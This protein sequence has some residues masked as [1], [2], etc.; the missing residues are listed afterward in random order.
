MGLTTPLRRELKQRFFPLLGEKG[1]IQ[2][3][4]D[5]PHT[6]H[7]RRPAGDVVHLLEVQWDKYGGPTFVINFGTCPAGG[8]NTPNGQFPVEQVYT[9]WLRES[10]RLQPKRGRGTSSWFSQKK[11]WLRRIFAKQE[12]RPPDEVVGEL[13]ALFP[14]VETYWTTGAIGHNLLMVR[15]PDR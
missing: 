4:R 1:F 2:D 6:I 10:G 9:G 7:F 11:P 13:L 8:L 14:Q 5:A 15:F 12:F 3:D